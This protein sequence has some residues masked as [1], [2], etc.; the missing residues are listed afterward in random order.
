MLKPKYSKIELAF[1]KATYKCQLKFTWFTE[2]K[3]LFHSS[4]LSTLT[5]IHKLYNYCIHTNPY[6]KR[7]V[8]FNSETLHSVNK[9]L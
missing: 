9:S 4:L 2:H 6:P 5:E 7:Y 8:R 1:S 3:L